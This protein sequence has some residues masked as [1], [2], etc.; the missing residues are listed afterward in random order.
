MGTVTALA[1]CASGEQ[2]ARMAGKSAMLSPATWPPLLSAP[3]MVDSAPLD[4]A[5]E[6]SGLH[7]NDLERA[8]R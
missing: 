6:F 5:I 1:P 3:A 7:L 8:R 2:M 4:G